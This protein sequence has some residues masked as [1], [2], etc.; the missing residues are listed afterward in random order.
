MYDK[1][2]NPF[3]KHVT[4]NCP[5][6]CG[7][8]PN[9][10]DDPAHLHILCSDVKSKELC[11]QQCMCNWDATS[12]SCASK[13]WTEALST[14]S[15]CY[16][17]P[18]FHN[19]TVCRKWIDRSCQNALEFDSTYTP[20]LI[21][22]LIDNCPDSCGTC[23]VYQPSWE[24]G[25]LSGDSCRD[26]EY[27]R[28]PYGNSCG[29]WATRNCAM[30][31]PLLEPVYPFRLLSQVRDHC[32][33]SCNICPPP[34]GECADNIAYQDIAGQG[35]SFYYSVRALGIPCVFF[36]Q[37]STQSVGRIDHAHESMIA[38]DNCKMSCANCM[39]PAK[40]SKRDGDCTDNLE[41]EFPMGLLFQGCPLEN[42][43]ALARA[44]P[45]S[46]LN[47]QTRACLI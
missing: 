40:E 7:L 33:A 11:S 9:D 31:D 41:Y 10:E 16:D 24:F 2:K 13:S 37:A 22:Q 29:D 26:D 27:F 12:A 19:G 4:Q 15:R 32:P 36:P 17:N 21:E 35:C 28:D 42:K 34:K 30:M 20:E 23:P 6:S 46:F 38:M 25:A 14:R 47:L 44:A 3:P 45:L 39:L 43:S 8:C 18:N 1:T 5:R